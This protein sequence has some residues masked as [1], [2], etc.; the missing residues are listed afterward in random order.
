MDG[1]KDKRR[2]LAHGRMDF[3]PDTYGE[4]RDSERPQASKLSAW[5]VAAKAMRGRGV[6]SPL[7]S[8]GPF[9]PLEGQMTLL[10]PK[11]PRTEHL[12]IFRERHPIVTDLPQC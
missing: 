9:A 5:L 12:T 1:K 4:C 2:V 10:P 6:I 3:V 8:N 11:M 7:G